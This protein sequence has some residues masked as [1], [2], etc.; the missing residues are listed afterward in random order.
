[1]V[2]KREELLLLFD[3]DGTLTKPRTDIEPAFAD[4][5]LNKVL[6]RATVG[7]VGGS[8]FGKILEQLGGRKVLDKLDYVFPENGTIHIEKG[9]E[10]GK[11]SIQQHLGEDKLQKFINFCLRYLSEITLPCKR[12]LFIEFRNGMLNISPVGRQCSRE[13]RNAFE[14][15]DNENHIR[16]NMIEALKAEFPDL[17]LTYSIGGQISFDVFPTGWDKTYC[18][19]H[20]AGE[21]KKFKEIHFFGDKTE[22]GG[23]DYEIFVD[24]RTIGH[25]VK[26]PEDTKKFLDEL[27]DLS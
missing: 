12:G 24:E 21:E 27:L 10:I 7:V 13:E 20:V 15:Y 6:P 1:M 3:L 8:D 22:P 11:K 26:S 2:H 25:R 5:L 14:K 19:R 4:Y 18:L 23:N 9:V 16:K 17:G